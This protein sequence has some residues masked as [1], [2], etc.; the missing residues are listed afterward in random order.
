MN[1]FKKKLHNLFFH[2]LAKSS[3]VVL[4]GTMI[5]NIAAY[6]YHLILGRILGPEGYG[7][8][9]S[10][11]SLLYIFGVP[12]LVLQTVL[13]KYFS[14]YK[15]SGTLGQTKDLFIRASFAVVIALFI[16]GI[17][18]LVTA[19]GV[20][21]FLHIRSP[22]SL[23][24]IYGILSFS[25]LSIIN[26]SVLM[27]YQHFL[28]YSFF[29][30]FAIVLKLIISVPLAYQGVS[31]ALAGGVFSGAMIYV[32]YQLAIA[33]VYR[34]NQ[35]KHGMKT[36]QIL[37]YSLPTLLAILGMTS[38]YSTDI[39]MVR[40]FFTI[41]ES[42]IYAAVAILGKVIF[43][44]SSAIATVLFPVIAERTAQK[45]NA[46]KLV[47]VGFLVICGISIMLVGLYTLFPTFIT[48]ALFGSRF[49]GAIQYLGLFAVFMTLF[50]LSNLFTTIC[51]SLGKTAVWL[52]TITASLLQIAA[53]SVI[54]H[55]LFSIIWINIT[56]CFVMFIGVV[57]YYK[58]GKTSTHI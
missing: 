57:F 4:I 50:S 43:Y 42:G 48:H 51:L 7:E 19:P 14:S 16:F 3:L 55:S 2:P 32:G 10:L 44:A 37:S 52:F 17:V 22:I 25:T 21:S 28:L 9:S 12:S 23:V 29:T 46:Y 35:E 24:L 49:D 8:L 31:W 5:S 33:F 30:A 6:L 11:I 15:A 54:H 40:H 27:G 47:W 39:M 53:I 26:T 58:Y 34:A 36:T 1:I 38:L 56:V 20:L 45:Q 18:L 13:T 41:H